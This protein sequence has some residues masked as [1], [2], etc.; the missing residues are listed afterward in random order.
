MDE[1]ASPSTVDKIMRVQSGWIPEYDVLSR[2]ISELECF[3]IEGKT[4]EVIK[5]LLEIVPTFRPLNSNTSMQIIH[6]LDRETHR[7]G[8]ALVK[9]VAPTE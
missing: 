8:L 4:A 2:K 6:R 3:A 5:L 9:P 7:P 1:T